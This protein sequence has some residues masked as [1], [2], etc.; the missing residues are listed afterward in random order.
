MLGTATLVV[1]AIFAVASAI[2]LTAVWDNLHEASQCVL[3]RDQRQFMLMRDERM[4]FA[5]R[6]VLIV[7]GTS[8]VV[9]LGA[10]HYP[11]SLAGEFVMFST[12]FVLTLCYLVVTTLQRVMV[13]PWFRERVPPDWL[14]QSADQYFNISLST[15]DD[16]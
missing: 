3:K 10:A 9:L 5:V 13:N 6:A 12:A 8:V 11:S 14:S 15:E 4:P 16:G 2:L 7:S 1:A